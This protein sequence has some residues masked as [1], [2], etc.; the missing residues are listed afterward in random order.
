MAD[1]APS[2]FPRQTSSS[3]SGLIESPHTRGDLCRS[4]TTEPTS[5]PDRKD[6]H[7]MPLRFILRVRQLNRQLGRSN[8]VERPGVHARDSYVLS[9]GDHA[10]GLPRFHDCSLDHLK[11]RSLAIRPIFALS[12]AA[13]RRAMCKA[14][15]ADFPLGTPEQAATAQDLRPTYCACTPKSC[16]NSAPQSVSKS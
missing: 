10:N 12:I 4:K 2:A 8:P 13:I 5:S 3:L 7:E 14:N 1:S 15:P 6:P 9:L 11:R 16:T